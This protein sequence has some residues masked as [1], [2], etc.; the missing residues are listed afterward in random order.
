MTQAPTVAQRLDHGL[1][2]ADDL[3]RQ[4]QYD[5]AVE[6]MAGLLSLADRECGA[7]SV[8]AAGVR[9]DYGVLLKA[10]GQYREARTLYQQAL[11]AL[12]DGPAG[13]R[14]HDVAVL[15][16]NLAGIDLVLDDPTRAADWARRGLAI[17]RALVGPE[18][19]SVLLD[20]GNLA[21]ILI[22]LGELD[23]AELLLTHLLDRFV[24]LCGPDDYE[25]AVTL[26]NLGGLAA[27]R[28]RWASAGEHLRRAVQI[29]IGLLGTANPDLIRT[30]INL[31][32]V[33]ENLGEQHESDQAHTHALQIARA[34][35]PPDNPLRLA[36]ENW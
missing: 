20:E 12:L 22:T 18:H 26:T 14:S 28:G 4:G 36:L 1:R 17:R 5:Q 33:A 24:A 30:L 19:P 8:A 35:L 29:K 16:H 21:P 34:S 15:Y 7:D 11:S 6:I 25:V 13:E 9:N 10:T 31:A 27:H 3:R 2:E 32:V 23:E